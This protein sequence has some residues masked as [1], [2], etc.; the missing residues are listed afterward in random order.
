MSCG[1]VGACRIEEFL[2]PGMLMG[3]VFFS[4]SNRINCSGQLN[5]SS[6]NRNLGYSVLVLRCK[7][8]D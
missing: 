1:E 4:D 3:A 7:L 5:S 8:I 6:F 2:L